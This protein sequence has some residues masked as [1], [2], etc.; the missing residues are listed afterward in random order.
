MVSRN[1]VLALIL[2]VAVS[3][4]GAA[5]AAEPAP[6]ST[7]SATVSTVTITVHSDAPSC[8]GLSPD[9]ARRLAQDAS[10][11]GAHAKAAECFRIAGDL[12]RSDRA[13]MRASA[14]EGAASVERIKANVESAKAQVKRMRAGFRKL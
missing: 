7:S 1:P 9:E 13:H 12:V 2:S 11:V 14:D 4:M 10:K 5:R 8:E 3:A 6:E